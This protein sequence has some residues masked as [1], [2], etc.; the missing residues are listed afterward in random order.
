[1]AS[2]G[3]QGR[4]VSRQGQL[5]SQAEAWGLEGRLGKQ[6]PQVSLTAPPRPRT[7]TKDPAPSP[8]KTRRKRKETPEEEVRSSQL[9]HLLVQR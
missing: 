3:T 5:T 2:E 1:M 7:L 4:R 9:C 8:R 6:G